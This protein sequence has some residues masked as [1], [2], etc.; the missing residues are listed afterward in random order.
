MSSQPLVC[1]TVTVNSPATDK[2]PD[3]ILGSKELD[4]IE[5]QLAPFDIDFD[6]IQKEFVNALRLLDAGLLSPNGV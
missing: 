3:T 1:N 4:K 6:E 5:P 2:G